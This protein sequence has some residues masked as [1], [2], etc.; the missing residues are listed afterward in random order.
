MK[1]RDRVWMRSMLT[2]GSI[3]LVTPVHAAESASAVAATNS[4]VTAES[5]LEEV[6][7]RDKLTGD[8][9]GLRSD[10][11]KHGIDID[12]RLSEYYQNVTTG[13]V[14]ENDEFGGTMDYRVNVDAHKLFG[15]WQNL[16]LNMHA[17]TRWGQDSNSDAGA[18]VLP[19][20]GMLMP[21]PGRYHGTDITGLSISQLFPFVAERTGSVTVGKLD[22]IDLVT[23][24][25]PNIGY[26]QEGFLNVNAQVSAMPWFGSV[27]GLALYGGMGVTIH[28]KYDVP[29]SGVVVAG[30]RNV[31]TDWGSLNDSFDD[32]SFLA[33][34]QRFFWDMD[35][36]MGYFMIFAGG[37]TK[38]QASNDPHD[39]IQIPG[40]GIESTE[41]KEPWDVALYLYQDIWQAKDNSSRKANIL[42]GGTVGPDNPQFSQY[43]FFANVEM[44]GLMESRPRD[45]MGVGG[46]WNSLS[47]DFEDLADLAGLNLQDTWG[48]ELYYNY[49]LTPWAHVSA[50]V[51]LVENQNVDDD[52]AIITGAR[53]VVDI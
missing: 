43:N 27:Q 40:Q 20:A 52:F 28:P 21:S 45:R 50:D 12:L 6:W 2:V 16:S 32:G 48:F 31:A 34:F 23:G 37:S 25:F 47:D 19:N 24:F 30:T 41:D 39:F 49:E 53:M 36:K 15:T 9:R 13:G 22:V 8:W 26:G 3:L 46:W 38:D 51:Q 17:R 33:A 18:L 44:F 42:I 29:E 7:T 5:Y 10:I 11:S 4:E 1:D 14:H 35:D